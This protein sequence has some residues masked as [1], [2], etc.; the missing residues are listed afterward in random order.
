[1]AKRKATTDMKE[2]VQ[3]IGIVDALEVFSRQ[4]MQVSIINSYD[5]V[6]PAQHTYTGSS[7]VTFEIPA[8]Q[9]L[10]LDP[11]SVYV[12]YRA[13]IS[14]VDGSKIA[15]LSKTAPCSNMAGT[16]WSD[17]EVQL[18]SC[19]ISQRSGLHGCV[20]VLLLLYSSSNTM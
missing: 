3:P 16:I 10:F 17:I 5:Y 14:E 2:V 4:K 20:L 13:W 12:S 6:V 8:H 19:V 9:K 1:M 18:N 15:D 11:H 7:P